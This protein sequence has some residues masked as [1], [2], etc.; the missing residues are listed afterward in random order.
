[1]KQTQFESEAECSVLTVTSATATGDGAVGG[2]GGAA[3][4]FRILNRMHELVEELRN[5]RWNFASVIYLEY[6]LLHEDTQGSDLLREATIEDRMRQYERKKHFIFVGTVQLDGVLVGADLPIL[7]QGD[8]V[9]GG[10]LCGHS[11]PSTEKPD[12]VVQIVG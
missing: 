6:H 9:V 11:R 12:E 5:G 10:A 8:A 3:E 1:M 7:H 4:L 2:G